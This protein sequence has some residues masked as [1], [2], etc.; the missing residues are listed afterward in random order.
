MCLLDRGLVTPRTHEQGEA[1]KDCKSSSGR[2]GKVDGVQVLVCRDKPLSFLFP[3]VHHQRLFVCRDLPRLADASPYV[4]DLIS[5]LRPVVGAA[6][7]D[8]M[9]P[10]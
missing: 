5:T 6:P 2:R 1:Q 8:C 9:P 10:T 4:L 3:D 7:S